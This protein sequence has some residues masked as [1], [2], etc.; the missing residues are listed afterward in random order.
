MRPSLTG[1]AA[2]ALVTSVL[3]VAACS[4]QATPTPIPS[5]ATPAPSPLAAG[6]YTST[7]FQPPV[8]YTVPAGWTNPEDRAPY[9]LLQP[10]GADV[11]G[12]HLFRDAVA[13]SQDQD[14]LTTPAPGVGTTAA[15]LVAWFGERPGL[16][17][18]EPVAVTTGGLRGFVVDISIVDGWLASCPFA[19]GIPTVPLLIIQESKYPWT[20]A[21]SER[22]RTS[23]LDV[24]G[25]GTVIIDLD[26]FAGDLFDDFVEQASPIV[27]SMQFEAD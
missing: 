25:G 15:E 22:L 20:V 5:A 19:N 7:A 4:A 2:V 8:T 1:L 16:V 18:S 12:I 13:A 11:V 27:A 6:T 9:F 3:A 26:D 14:C 10:V 23:V 17:V 21:G 24:P